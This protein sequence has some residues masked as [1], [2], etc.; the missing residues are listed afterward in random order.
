MKYT[1]LDEAVHAWVA[2]FNAIPYTLLE[3]AYPGFEDDGVTTLVM[4]RYCANC[5]NEFGT[6]NEDGDTVC[7]RCGHGVDGWDTLDRW[8]MWSTLW[9]FGSRFDEEWARTHLDEM[10]RCGFWVYESDELGLF[11]GINGAGYDFY[12]AHW[13]ALYRARGLRWHACAV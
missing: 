12:E 3:K 2:E 6:E 1:T 10:R 11:F 4:D 5:G 9:T 13:T 8:P 7:D